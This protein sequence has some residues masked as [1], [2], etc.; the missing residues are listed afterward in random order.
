MNS[1][2]LSIITPIYNNINDT[3]Q[4]LKQ[5]KYYTQS[6]YELITMDNGSYKKTIKLLNT[7]SEDGNIKVIKNKKNMDYEYAN[8]QGIEIADFK[9][10]CFM[11]NN[12]VVKIIA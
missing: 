9:Y 7:L 11:N 3:K 1:F 12:A 5:I 4:Y 6:A 2:K 8:N 10:I